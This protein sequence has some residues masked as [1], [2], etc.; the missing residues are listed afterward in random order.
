MS[1]EN[2]RFFGTDVKVSKK[3]TPKRNAR[4]TIRV[5]ATASLAA[6]AAVASI[7][8]PA[9]VTHTPHSPNAQ[10]RALAKSV[11][12][13]C[14]AVSPTLCGHLTASDDVSEALRAS[15]L[16][17]SLSTPQK[18]AQ[19]FVVTP[20]SL[21]AGY[22]DDTVTQSGDLTRQALAE[23]P[24]GGIVYFQQNLL[25]ADQTRAML[26]QANSYALESC[27]IP[28]LLDV[29][30]EG[31][32]VSRIGGNEGFG[33]E[34]VGNMSAVGATGDPAVAA[35]TATTIASYLADLG[36]TSDFAPVADVADNPDSDTMALR[37]FGSDAQLVAQMVSAQ[38]SAFNDA[39]VICCAKHFP[40]IG[41][42]EGDSH[43]GAIYTHK[44]ADQMA[45]VE[46]VP[47]S[48]AIDAGVPMVMVGH[49]SCPEV[50]GDDL[51]ASVS[52]AV[53]H[54][55]LRERLG[56]GGVIITDSLGMGAIVDRFGYDRVAVEAFKAGAD[57]LLMPADFDAAYQG[58][59]DA[60]ES[61]EIDQGRL[62]LSC[63]RI[64]RMK[65]HR[66]ASA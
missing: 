39:H 50:T 23:R 53:M 52:P 29:D 7:V 42:A 41:G 10:E 58:M 16:V 37:S 3:S 63:W 15:E 43:N 13:A 18:V 8:V 4:R 55:L 64:V 61:G 66:E 32:T 65:L 2:L 40:G 38:V 44:T 59:L 46:L 45:E 27:G 20:E 12:Q 30:E 36:F 19:L 9:I 28:L 60:V 47:F 54:D 1:T 17:H 31:G 5:L 48:A 6:L 14:V 51:P 34:N 21:V 11:V 57:A 62:D 24:V 26:E 25:D 33:I 22:Y 35:N 56:F 49:I